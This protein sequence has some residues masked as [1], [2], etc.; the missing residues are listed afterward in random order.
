MPFIISGPSVV[1]P[2]RV[3][4]ALVNTQDLFA[5]ILELFGYTTWQSQISASKPVDSKSILPI[6]KNEA[7]DVRDW[8]FTEVFSTPSVSTNGK[9]DAEQTIQTVRL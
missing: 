1:N 8:I 4:S 2:N 3:S 6:L 5:T 7:V 9:N